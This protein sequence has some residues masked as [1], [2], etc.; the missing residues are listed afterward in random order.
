MSHDAENSMTSKYMNLS[1]ALE[2]SCDTKFPN[3]ENPR[4]DIICI[5]ALFLLPNQS[6][7]RF[8]DPE[9]P[10]NDIYLEP[11]DTPLALIP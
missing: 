8:R 11:M 4:N 10:R 3:L 9:T 2:V 6:Q 7:K 1:A 5:C